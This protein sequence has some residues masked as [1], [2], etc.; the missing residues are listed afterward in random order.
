MVPPA[1]STGHA[2]GLSTRIRCHSRFGS[3]VHDSAIPGE[4]ATASVGQPVW[5]V[6]R[7]PIV[8]SVARVATGRWI[9]PTASNALT[10]PG[11]RRTEIFAS[12]VRPSKVPAPRS[13]RRGV[14]DVWAGQGGSQAARRSS[15]AIMGAPRARAS[16]VRVGRSGP[17]ILWDTRRR[18]DARCP[19]RRRGAGGAAAG[20]PAWSPAGRRRARTCSRLRSTRT[21][22]R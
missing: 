20:R 16:V 21:G 9:S 15:A 5:A 6:S 1:R 11:D 12:A 22:P 4:D 2:S 8:H 17:R 3:M 13:S 10:P 18:G 7:H 19:P 14:E